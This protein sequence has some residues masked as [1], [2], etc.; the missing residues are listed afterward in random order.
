MLKT[1]T[2][3]KKEYPAILKYFYKCK[4]GRDDLSSWCKKCFSVYTKKYREEKK[5]E[6]KEYQKNGMK[7]IQ[8]N[9]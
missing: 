3:C 8:E 4:T 6:Y 9:K 5:R 2:I 7:K 1:C